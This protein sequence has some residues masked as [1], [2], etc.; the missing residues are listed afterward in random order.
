MFNATHVYIII[1]NPSRMLSLGSDLYEEPIV[2]NL[3][4]GNKKDEVV[5]LK[6]FKYLSF[7]PFR[8]ENVIFMIICKKAYFPYS[9]IVLDVKDER[10]FCCHE[11]F[12]DTISFTDTFLVWVDHFKIVQFEYHNFSQTL[13]HLRYQLRQ[14][15]IILLKKK[16]AFLTIRHIFKVVF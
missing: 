3:H 4:F 7:Q 9:C 6:S 12:S 8:W 15:L 13:D 10:P 2:N 1:P 14:I 16:M 11:Q 5:A